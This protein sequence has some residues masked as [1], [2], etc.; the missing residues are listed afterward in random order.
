MHLIRK[1]A[2]IVGFLL[3][4]ATCIQFPTPRRTFFSTF[5]GYALPISSV[6][7]LN[8]DEFEITYDPAKGPLGLVLQDVTFSTALRVQIKSISPTSQILSQSPFQSHIK[9][10]SS[11]YLSS[12]EE[13]LSDVKKGVAGEP[14][15]IISSINGI[16]TERTNAQGVRQILSSEIPKMNG[17]PIR[18]VLKS[19][20]GFNERLR[21]LK[22]E[23][24]VSTNIS[25]KSDTSEAGDLR[26]MQLRRPLTVDA[27]IAGFGDLVEIAYKA[28]YLPKNV[29]DVEKGGGRVPFDSSSVRNDDTTIQFV[30]GKQPFGQFPPAFN[31]GIENMRIGEVRG[32]EVPSVLGY[33]EEGLKKFGVPSGVRLYF[34]IELKAVNALYK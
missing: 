34:E 18:I 12:Y 14:G 1:S 11:T 26:V 32:V 16:S 8:S 13:Y 3:Q 27:T 33:G 5:I 30:L 21:D 20:S 24:N 28:Y 29:E 4:F 7:A 17:E 23:E 25:P 15:L 10:I 9:R 2:I 6:F 31:V 19:S 22:E